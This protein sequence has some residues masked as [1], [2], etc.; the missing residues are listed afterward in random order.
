MSIWRVSFWFHEEMNKC[1]LC[2]VFSGSAILTQYGTIWMEEAFS[3][4]C[5]S[6][7]SL[8]GPRWSLLLEKWHFWSKFF[9]VLYCFLIWFFLVWRIQRKFSKSFPSLKLNGL[10]ALM[11]F[12][13]KSLWNLWKQLLGFWGNKGSEL[14]FEGFLL[15]VI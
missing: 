6:E 11:Q 1:Q 15:G 9:A 2:E 14:K 7:R 8:M 12:I 10:I 3:L 13:W 4:H 5:C